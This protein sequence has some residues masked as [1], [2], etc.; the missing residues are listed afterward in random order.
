MMTTTK[1]KFMA[2]KSVHLA[3]ASASGDHASGQADPAYG[4]LVRQMS[5]ERSKIRTLMATILA[6]FE[7][8]F[9]RYGKGPNGIIGIT[10]KPNTL[11]SGLWVFT[12]AVF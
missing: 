6:Q 10:L 5:A 9:M 12:F 2:P 8:T 3:T 4:K 1:T 11:N 7:T